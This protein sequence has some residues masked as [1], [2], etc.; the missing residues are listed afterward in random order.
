M[1]TT[2]TTCLFSSKPHPAHRVLVTGS[3][4]KNRQGRIN[5]L[6]S[7]PASFQVL[8]IDH[9]GIQSQVAKAQSE[10]EYYNDIQNYM[11]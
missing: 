1:K 10:K 7:S 11:K 2:S 9:G 3:L 6:P 8:G 5:V 4:P